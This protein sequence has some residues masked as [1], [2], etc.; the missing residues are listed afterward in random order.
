MLNIIEVG[1]EVNIDDSSL[2][3][4]DCLGYPVYR[5]MCCP[6]RSVSIRPR[7][8]VSFE[9]RLQNELECPL[10]NTIADRRNRQNADF[11]APVLGYF[12]LPRPHGPI[13]VGDQFV[14]YLLQ[15][16]LHSAFLDS[17]ERDSVYSRCPVVFLRHPVGLVE[18][19]P[20]ADVDVESPE[21]PGGFRLRLDV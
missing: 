9:D 2:L 21:T 13:R 15:K 11:L 12:L 20:F 10:N 8:E 4:N 3:F 5:L 14:P 17:L 1:A 18:R 6:F 16:T 7:L 19:L